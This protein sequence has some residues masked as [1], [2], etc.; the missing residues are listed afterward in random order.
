M[1]DEV[2]VRALLV[3]SRQQV[4][5]HLEVLL[6]ALFDALSAP[7]DRVVL[8]ALSVQVLSYITPGQSSPP[9]LC[10]Q[11]RMRHTHEHKHRCTYTKLR[12]RHGCNACRSYQLTSSLLQTSLHDMAQL[13]LVTVYWRHSCLEHRH[14]D[15]SSHSQAQPGGRHIMFVII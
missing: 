14:N 11:Q 13:H 2:Q 5:G 3:R 12:L 15:I 10:L 7:S 8:E 9:S 6:P 1:S 4:L